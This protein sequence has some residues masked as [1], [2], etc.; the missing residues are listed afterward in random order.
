MAD[1]NLTIEVIY[2][3]HGATAKLKELDRTIDG[4]GQTTSQKT[5]PA[6]SGMS[7]MLKGALVGAAVTAAY[8][9]GAL[10]VELVQMSD[11]IKRVSDRTGLSIKA[12]Q[13]LGYAAEQSGNSL[14]QITA[15][16]G[17]MQNRLASGDKSA[18]AAVEAL[19]LNLQQII[20]LSPDEQFY[21]LAKA[22]GEVED[23][24]KRTQLAMDLFGR[25]GAA[26]LPT[27][28]AD[29]QKLRDEAPV[30]ADRTVTALD[31]MG[32][33]WQRLKLTTK[34]AVAE[35][36]VGL[37]TYADA[38]FS[39][40]IGGMI[41]Q[42]TVGAF[43]GNSKGRDT[44]LVDVVPA[45]TDYTVTVKAAAAA[46]KRRRLTPRSSPPRCPRWRWAPRRRCRRCR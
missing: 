2:D 6:V 33:A 3:D 39:S 26:I 7:T 43:G 38:F 24:M 8:Q 44:Q 34:V 21:A 11:E 41:A 28:I 1:K 18:V 20:S 10:A 16:L 42:G 46:T 5:T 30:L 13:Q 12:V 17:Q 35:G 25:S 22:I 19:G 40:G 23:P 27:L 37:A 14:D 29:M 15:A 36:V 4:V 31:R 32:D 9:V 45:V